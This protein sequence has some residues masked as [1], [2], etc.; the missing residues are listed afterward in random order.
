MSP[1]HLQVTGVSEGK[2]TI[3]VTSQGVTGQ[4]TVTVRDRA[5]LAWSIPLSGEYVHGE[6]AIG[7]DGTIYVVTSGGDRSTWYAVSPQGAVLWSMDLPTSFTTPAVGADG[8]LYGSLLD[9]GLIAVSPAG[10]V[11][12]TLSDLNGIRSSPAI[13]Q[14]GTIYVAG[15]DRVYAVSPQGDIRWTYET[16]ESVFA[17][18]S[19]AV[20][21]D[22]TIYVG[23]N[24]GGLY[25]INRDGSPRWTFS[26]GDKN[27]IYSGPS[28]D[29]DGTI[30]FGAL[31][32]LYAVGPDGS[33]GVRLLDRTVHRSPSIGPDAIHVGAGGD[34]GIGVHAF[35]PNGSVRWSSMPSASSTPILGADGTVYVTGGDPRGPAILAALDS[36]ARLQWDYVAPAGNFVLQSPAIGVD[37]M[38]LAVTRDPIVLYAIT[39]KSST[40]GGYA[41]APWP[42]ARGDRANTGRARR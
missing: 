39:E 17:H 2:A 42:T 9:G 38:I 4:M 25:A 12:W 3:S 35:D 23:G 27:Y 32:G 5:R 6:I 15:L 34:R 20:A 28:I 14:D 11:R 33:G 22:G 21:S 8:T 36:Q 10:T 26:V 29:R 24:D 19:P 40:N 16:T 7:G 41:G 37:G 18:S 1:H 31:H 13:G 30:Y